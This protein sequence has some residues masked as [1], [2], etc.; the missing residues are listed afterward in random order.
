MQSA[1][2]AIDL[3]GAYDP[4]IAVLAGVV[5]AVAMLMVIYGGRAM[6]MTSMDLLRTLG[7]MIKPHGSDT[8]ARA[9]GL[10]MHLMMGAGFGLVHAGLLHAANPSSEGAATAAGAL[11]GL[12]HGALVVA[13]MPVMLQMAHP[14][15]AAGDI[16]APRVAMTGFGKLTPVGMVMA[17]VVF[18]LVAGWIYTAVVG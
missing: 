16:P 8:S 2:L 3:A 18:G 1:V 17:H 14:L 7:T 9:I 10:M 4:G 12:V 11:F 5:G 13:M 15:V 6:G